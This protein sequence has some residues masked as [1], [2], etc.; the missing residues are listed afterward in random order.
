MVSYGWPGL[1]ALVGH[2]SIYSLDVGIVEPQ[3]TAGMP[4]LLLCLHPV[5]LHEIEIASKV[6]LR[7]E[8]SI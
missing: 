2:F 3:R 6:N 1:N 4:A 8:S 7:V 5:G